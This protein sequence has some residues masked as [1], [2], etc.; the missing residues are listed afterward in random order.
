MLIQALGYV[1]ST[2]V[3]VAFYMRTMLPLL[4]GWC[5]VPLAAWVCFATVLN[6]AIWTPNS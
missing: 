5:L 6:F 2:P 1:A 3:F 4:A